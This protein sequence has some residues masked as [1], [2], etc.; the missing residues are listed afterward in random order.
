MSEYCKTR[1]GVRYPSPPPGHCSSVNSVNIGH[2][3]TTVSQPSIFRPPGEHTLNNSKNVA[4]NL[5]SLWKL[6]V[7]T[8]CLLMTYLSAG[9]HDS[10]PEEDDTEDIKPDLSVT[11][12]SLAGSTQLTSPAAYPAS[13][14]RFIH[15]QVYRHYHPYLH[16]QNLH[17][18]FSSLYNQK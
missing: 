11:S 16:I 14:L 3:T 10:D 6:E 2:E 5:L 12:A 7:V 18:Y 4:K 17:P 15:P 1:A 9:M 8:K 13:M